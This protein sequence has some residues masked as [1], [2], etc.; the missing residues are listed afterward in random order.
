[1][2]DEEDN[3]NYGEYEEEDDDNLEVN[4]WVWR[5]HEGY[6]ISIFVLGGL[7]SQERPAAGKRKGKKLR[8]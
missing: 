2:S 6:C 3:D 5:G 1:M 8:D 7:L 4:K